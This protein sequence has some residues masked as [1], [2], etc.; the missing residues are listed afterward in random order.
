MNYKHHTMELRETVRGRLSKKSFLRGIN[1]FSTVE[2]MMQRS[3]WH[4]THPAGAMP[5]A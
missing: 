5:A 2:L 4:L 1:Q 3:G